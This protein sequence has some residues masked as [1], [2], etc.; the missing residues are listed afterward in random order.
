MQEAMGE[1]AMDDCTGSTFPDTA[2]AL[3][4]DFF[5][6]ESLPIGLVVV[7]AGAHIISVNDYVE[8]ILGFDR[9][10]LLGQ[11]VEMLF[12]ER[13]R[14]KHGNLR[15]VFAAGPRE[16]PIG[17][18]H[19]LC[20]RRR[21]G[22]E[23]PVEIGLKPI[24]REGRYY[25]LTIMVDISERKRLE[26]QRLL[27]GELNHRIQNLF[28]VVQSV[29]LHSLRGDRSLEDAREVFIER[30]H[31][32]GRTYTLMTEQEWR[33]APLRQLVAAETST[34]ADRINLAGTDV[35]VRERAAQSF[36]MIVHELTTNAVKCGALSVPAGR[37]D[38][39]WSVGGDDHPG[40]FS[41]S[42]Q[43]TGGPTVVP[44]SVTGYGRKIIEST[45]R[46]IGKYQIEY[47]PSGLEF[48]ME[49]PLDKIGWVIQQ[50]TEA[51]S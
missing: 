47:A 19:D 4:P 12:P 14:I 30:L 46:R 24:R 50:P 43:E 7:D 39:R 17:A 37:V 18:G 35:M 11:S 8:Q 23:I 15:R 20:A 33:A 29:A 31:S 16:Q 28:A 3:F 32:L 26:E 25:V 10:E 27:I 38:V 13:S 49:V 5:L 36:A 2:K 51:V 42:W 34:F 45:M 22:T 48:S 21:D 40:M 41:L 1:Y 9:D 6:L 44:P